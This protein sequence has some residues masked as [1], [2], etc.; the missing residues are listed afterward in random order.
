[1][2]ETKKGAV[3][4]YLII[5]LVLGA[6]TYVE[7]A[8]VEYQ[9][10]ISWIN[11]TWTIIL[12]VVL[13]LIKFALV[14]AIYMHLRDDDPIYTGFFSSGMIIALGT[15][16]ALSFLFT[17]RSVNAYRTQ[18]AETETHGEVIAEDTSHGEEVGHGEEEEHAVELEPH[19]TLAEAFRVPS[20]KNQSAVQ[21]SLPRAPVAE[22][23]LR[24]PG[25][26]MAAG[27]E[28]VSEANME[29]EAATEEATETDAAEE[30]TQEEAET[31]EETSTEEATDSEEVLAQTA[32]F[33][34]QELGETTYTS[35]CVACHQASGEGVPAA[36]PPLAGHMPALFNAEG[37]KEYLINVILY[38][39]Q[40]EIEVDSTTYNSVMTPWAASL[41]DEQI[42]ATLNH[43][44]TNWGNDALIEDFSPI[45]PED[46]AA[47]RDLGLSSADVLGLRP[48]LP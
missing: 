18:Q 5:A 41:D 19:K 3:A 48:E 36:F 42:A 37:G 17:V 1:M 21:V 4:F 10:A 46:V 24:L 27:A 23:S 6:I 15:F 39:L 31:A 12:L 33:D 7:F 26:A 8:I 35:F 9:D 40:G 11:A 45:L 44:L 30:D 14:V 20:P 13:S 34:W 32:D 25:L 43:E 38:G 22:Y 47:L 2:A 16:V 28:E 29:A